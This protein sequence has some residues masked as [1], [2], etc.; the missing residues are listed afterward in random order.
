MSG[1]GWHPVIIVGAIT[2][3]CITVS[4]T[5]AKQLN[6][7]ILGEEEAML[8]G[9]N[10]KRLKRN[11]LLLNVAMIAVATA[12]VG[13][14]TFVGLVVPHLLRIWRGSDNRYLILGGSLLGALLLCAADIVARLALSPAELPIGIVT[15]IVGVPVFIY[16][17]RNKTYY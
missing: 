17:L 3:L 11:V 16:L 5:Y 12:F 1:A 2:V 10:V 15:A 8:I 9:V 13:V 6:A 4:L 14:I 7:L